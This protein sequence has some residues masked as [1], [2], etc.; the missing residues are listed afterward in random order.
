MEEDV[1]AQTVASYRIV[2]VIG[3]EGNPVLIQLFRA[4]H[5]YTL[6][7]VFVILDDGKCSKGLSQ[8]HTVG[9]NTAVV[10]LQLVDDSEC[11]ILL[12]VV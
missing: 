10:F 4:K 8:S 5:Q 12:E 2:L 9:K 3:T 11:R 6:V 7:A 1:V